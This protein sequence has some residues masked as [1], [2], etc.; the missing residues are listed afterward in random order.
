MVS[1]QQGLE[2]PLVWLRWE[3]LNSLWLKRLSREWVETQ[4]VL[5]KSLIFLEI[6]Q[7]SQRQPKL[8]DKHKR[9]QRIQMKMN[10]SE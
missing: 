9:I 8:L 10:Q 6:A 5:Q 1:T 7:V 3:K 4:V 2:K